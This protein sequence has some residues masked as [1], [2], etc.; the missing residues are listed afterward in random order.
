M[1]D[2]VNPNALYTE[3]ETRHLLGDIGKSKLYEYR[4]ARLIAPCRKKP[5][6][7]F[8]QEI[9]NSMSRITEY[10][11]NGGNRPDLSEYGIE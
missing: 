2:N 11:R 9:L 8:G 3:E 7:F 1:I 4:N 5:T 6:M 10:N